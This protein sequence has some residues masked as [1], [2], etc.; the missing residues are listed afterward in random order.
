MSTKE[1]ANNITPPSTEPY[2]PGQ[3]VLCRVEGIEPGGYSAVIQGGGPPF[4]GEEENPD[5]HLHAFLPSTDSLKIGQVVP[6][7]F[8]CMHNNR[9]LMT[10]AFMLGTCEKVQKSTA[11]DGENAFSIWVD[12]YPSSQ[13]TRRAIDLF[14]PSVSGKLLHELKCSK[15][16]TS[17]ILKELELAQFTGCIKSRNEEKKSRSAMLIVDGRIVGAIYGRKDAH[18]TFAV[19]KAITLMRED[20]LDG[21]TFLQV[22]ELPKA[23]V[24]SMS[25]LFLGCPLKREDNSSISDYLD[26]SLMSMSLAAETGCITYSQDG[27]R[28]DS[29]LFIHEGGPFAGYQIDSQQ[30]VENPEELL[31]SLKEKEQGQVEA[32]LLPNQLLSSSVVFG[33]KLTEY[34]ETTN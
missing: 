5:N 16:E 32:H 6:A 8:V 10:F 7:T 19:E 12:S 34:E 27:T 3:C 29:M 14:M 18:E 21:E 11:P 23:S 2:R 33:Y 15:E 28:T 17:R 22:Y 4:E 1:E 24:L 9:A 31:K 30:Y 26:I 13:K 25:S 20:M